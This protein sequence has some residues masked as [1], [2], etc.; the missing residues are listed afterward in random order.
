[1]QGQPPKVTKVP[2]TVSIKGALQNR[3]VIADIG[4]TGNKD[5]TEKSYKGFK[6]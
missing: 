1:M 5:D 2:R 3:A 4:G 6:L